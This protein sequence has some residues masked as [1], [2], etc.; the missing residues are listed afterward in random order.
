MIRSKE[1]KPVPLIEVDLT[2]PNGNVFRLMG[3]VRSWGR[4]LGYTEDRINAIQKV[5]MMGDY[6]GAIKVFDKE[7]GHFCTLWR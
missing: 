1:E 7:F 5:M 4:D 3:L 2:G 6:E